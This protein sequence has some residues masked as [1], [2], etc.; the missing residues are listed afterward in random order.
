MSIPNPYCNSYSEDIAIFTNGSQGCLIIN[1]PP[2]NRYPIITELNTFHE[3]M[4]AEAIEFEM[5]RGGQ[6]FSIHNQIA[7]H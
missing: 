5:S 2:P 3:E 4:V 6:I 1:T 7:E